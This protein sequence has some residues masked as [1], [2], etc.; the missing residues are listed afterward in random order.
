MGARTPAAVARIVAWLILLT[1]AVFLAEGLVLWL[2]HRPSLGLVCLAAVGLLAF[3][4]TFSR[5]VYDVVARSGARDRH[6]PDVAIC[7]SVAFALLLLLGGAWGALP[8]LAAC[9][10]VVSLSA[11]RS[12]WAATGIL[13]GMVLSGLLLG[14]PTD[15]VVDVVVRSVVTVVV[16]GALGLLPSFAREIHDNRAE[17]ARLAVVEERL[18]FARDLHDVLGH[19]LSVVGMKMEVAL[20]LLRNDPDR[21]RTEIEQALAV[22]RGSVSDLRS[23]VRG[24]RQPSLESE[25]EGVRSVLRSAGIACRTDQVPPDVPQPLQDAAGWVVREG[26]TNVLRHSAATECRIKLR[27]DDGRLLVEVA[28]DEARPN[29]ASDGNGLRGL[30]ERL[31]DIGGELTAGPDGSG[32]FRLLAHAPL[33]HTAF[34][35]AARDRTAHERTAQRGPA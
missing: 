15:L 24:Y 8:S 3:A 21:A 13:L 20:L 9:A 5:T 28:N 11:R 29:D 12:V 26:V 25:L 16:V 23:L 2:R 14:M 33:Q 22:S 4:V 35:P 32:G 1:A 19:G 7:T 31:T 17:L 10:A 27:V 34:G 30:R 6:V 18:R